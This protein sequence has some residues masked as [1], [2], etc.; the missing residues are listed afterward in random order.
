MAAGNT[1]IHKKYIFGLNDQNTFLTY[2]IY[3]HSSYLIVT[4]SWNF[5]SN[6]GNRD[7]LLS[8]SASCS[9]LLKPLQSHRGD[10]GV[11]L[12]VI[13]SFLPQWGLC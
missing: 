2:L 7:I 5:L 11:V 10:M 8:Y 3:V 13:S 9:Q 4:N 6:K 1:V 12:L